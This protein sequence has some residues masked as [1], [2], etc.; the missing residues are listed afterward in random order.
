MQNLKNTR[1]KLVV[2]ARAIWDITKDP[3]FSFR[4]LGNAFEIKG[5]TAHDVYVRSKGK[6]KLGVAFKVDKGHK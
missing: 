6:Y 4:K 2:I 3:D 1:N 5:E